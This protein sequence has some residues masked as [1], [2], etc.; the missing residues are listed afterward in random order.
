MEIKQKECFIP[1][2]VK[3]W[4][5]Q[6]VSKYTRAAAEFVNLYSKWR[7]TNRFPALTKTFDLLMDWP[8]VQKRKVEI[9]Q[10]QP[11]RDWIERESKLGNPTLTKEVEKTNDPVL[12]Q[13]LEWSMAVNASVADMVEGI[14]PFPYVRESLEK[15]GQKAD[16]IVVSATPFEALEREWKEHDIAK[17][18]AIIAGQEHGSK[19]EHLQFAASGKY[20]ENR[21]LMVGDAPGD[22]RAAQANN[23]L[24]YP[25]MPGH[26]DDSWERFHEEALDRFFEGNYAG[27]YERHLTDEFLASLPETPPWKK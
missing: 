22:L 20:G 19:K 21:I 13:A 12:R 18:A 9:P 4:K 1:N 7:G 17:Y 10:A 11:L 2:I 27:D 5:L 8:D 26:E 14:P 23:A 16:C 24:F 3:H 25:I 15:A 6:A